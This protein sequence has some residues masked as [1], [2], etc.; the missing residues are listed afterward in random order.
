MATIEEREKI[1]GLI[2]ANSVYN[3]S[4]F[5][6]QQLDELANLKYNAKLYDEDIIKIAQPQINAL[7]YNIIGDF[8]ITGGNFNAK[9]FNDYVRRDSTRIDDI[10][11]NVYLG[12]MRGL[13]NEQID[14]YAQSTTP[15]IKIARLLVEKCKDD[16]T[17]EELHKIVTKTFGNKSTLGKFIIQDF[18]NGNLEKEQLFAISNFETITQ[19]IYD[20]VL[21]ASKQE[22]A[23]LS[24][25]GDVT[26]FKYIKRVIAVIPSA[27]EYVDIVDNFEKHNITFESV[28]G[29]NKFRNFAS[30][31]FQFG[32]GIEKLTTVLEYQYITDAQIAT[33]IKA[34]NSV[35]DEY[36]ESYLGATTLDSYYKTLWMDAETRH[37]I[38]DLLSICW[39]D[40]TITDFTE[41]ELKRFA[42]LIKYEDAFYDI[43]DYTGSYDEVGHIINT[44]IHTIDISSLIEKIVSKGINPTIAIII[45]SAFE[46]VSDLDVDKVSDIIVKWK[47]S[48]ED[49]MKILYGIHN[50]IPDTQN[51]TVI[52]YLKNYP[53]IKD[54]D[55]IDVLYR[56]CKPGEV[57][58]FNKNDL[59]TED[60][61]IRF[62]EDI[63]VPKTTI[64]T[65]IPTYDFEEEDDDDY[66][67]EEYFEDSFEDSP[68]FEA[69]DIGSGI[70]IFAKE[71]ASD[72]I[73]QFKKED[74]K[75]EEYTYKFEIITK[76]EEFRHECK[77]KTKQDVVKAIN[78]TIQF[79]DGIKKYS[80]YVKELE[81]RRAKFE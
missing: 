55:N 64:V 80:K 40:T 63:S 72:P 17:E 78:M 4:A 60:V 37:S 70:A 49:T 76:N 43:G 58:E 20:F 2:M 61:I 1:K 30:R 21:T 57:E 12:K 81:D 69:K 52:F 15:D 27:M 47:Y 35:F 59:I 62:C 67:S 10:I 45:L 29:Y 77:V 46:N 8:V 50:H 31:Y 13:S 3:V 74:E 39:A 68:V 19:D 53:I 73:I 38:E 26:Y 22:L 75:K 33:I 36:V 71:L 54:L 56:H 51:E 66:I 23:I 42:Q 14:L 44:F 65:I 5:N 11:C 34:G 18:I 16:F 48:N 28:D 7:S 24:T 32:Q 9:E 25:L 6:E 41:E 79:I